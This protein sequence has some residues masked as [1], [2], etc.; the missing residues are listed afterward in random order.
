MAVR[1]RDGAAPSTALLQRELATIDPSLPLFRVEP[2]AVSLRGQNA[3]ARFGSLVLGAFSALALILAAIGIYGVTAFV[4]GL[5]SRE[6]AIRLALG[7][8][9]GKVLRVVMANGMTLVLIGLGLGVLG[10]RLGARLLESQLYGVRATDPVTLLAVSGAVV[11]VALLANW[12][13]ARRAA[14]VEPQVV[15]KGE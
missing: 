7:A 11:L 15:L 9:G 14:A 10:A 3:A 12:I 2:L 8:D 5:S 6:I 1:T 13:P 4:V